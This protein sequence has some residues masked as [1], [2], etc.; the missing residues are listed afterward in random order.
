[1]K[2]PIANVLKIER[3]YSKA[4]EVETEIDRIVVESGS[5]HLGNFDMVAWQGFKMK[6]V[7]ANMQKKVKSNYMRFP[8]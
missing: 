4:D 1:M 6:T 8:L 5:A 3:G 2:C 7:S